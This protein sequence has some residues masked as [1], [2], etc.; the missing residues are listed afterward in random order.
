MLTVHTTGFATEESGADGAS[1]Q[2]IYG[3]LAS[4]SAR[5]R[6]IAGHVAARI[7]R[8]RHCLILT[9]RLAH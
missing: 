2:A 9:N 3:E 4:D 7:A 8:G 1:I 5:N 6:L